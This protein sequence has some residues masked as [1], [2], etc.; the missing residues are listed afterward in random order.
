MKVQ[1]KIKQLE[2]IWTFKNKSVAYNFDSHVKKSVPLYEL[3]HK[4]AIDISN[5][6]LNK[7]STCYDLG[8]SNGSLLREID[9]KYSKKKLDLI[10][11][12]DS[13]A[14]IKLAQKKSNNKIQFIKSSLEEFKFKKSDL[15]YSL[16]TL[17]FITPG[18]RQKIYNNI[19][20]S[21]NNAGGFILYEKIRSSN[22]RFQ[23]INNF[24]YFDFK[25]SNGLT[26]QEIINKEI[27][28][29]GV[30]EPFTDKENL[31]FLKKAGFRKISTIFHYLNFKG[32]L[33]IK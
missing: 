16:Y 1:K 22:A 12:D 4:H 30:L 6:F 13:T 20:N 27:L 5:F 11:V 23:D 3:S 26:K 18:K 9:K 32:Y 28:L 7:G 29:R 2:R 21:L 24:L 8:C 14:M 31:N 17:Q 15:F 10:G 25:Y 33:A 19:Y